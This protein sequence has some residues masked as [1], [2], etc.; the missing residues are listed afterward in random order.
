MWLFNWETC[1]AFSVKCSSGEERPS[2]SNEGESSPGPFCERSTPL[3]SR[4]VEWFLSLQRS[5]WG[6]GRS[7]HCWSTFP[8]SL[9]GCPVLRSPR[10]ISLGWSAMAE[11]WRSLVELCGWACRLPNS[12]EADLA[13][14][15]V[16]KMSKTWRKGPGTLCVTETYRDS[17]HCGRAILKWILKCTFQRLESGRGFFFLNS[18]IRK[19]KPVLSLPCFLMLMWKTFHCHPMW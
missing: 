8:A 18:K 7:G 15:F 16:E 5:R 10:W 2:P 6:S 1:F 11:S 9:H 12:P 13:G 14:I 3:D 19:Q 17:L 4:G